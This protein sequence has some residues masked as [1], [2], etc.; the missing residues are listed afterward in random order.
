MRTGVDPH[1]RTMV[2]VRTGEDPHIRTKV[3]VRTREDSHIRTKFF[4]RTGEDPHVRTEVFVRTGE[5]PH[6]VRTCG[7]VRIAHPKC[8]KCE[9]VD[10][11][12]KQ[13]NISVYRG[14]M[15]HVE[16]HD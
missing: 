10:L 2:F 3:F 7:L 15:N 8:L 1:I 5:D 13:P 6:L 9:F 12:E 11:T 16:I 14:R 4:V